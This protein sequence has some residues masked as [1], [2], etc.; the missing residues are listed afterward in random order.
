MRTWFIGSVVGGL[1]LS[2][3]PK[4]QYEDQQVQLR[5]AQAQLRQVAAEAKDC[6]MDTFLQMREQAQ[7]LDLLTAELVDRNTELA[8]EVARL[9]TF[10]TQTRSRDLD[11]DGRIQNLNQEYE[12]RLQR[13]RATYDDMVRD[14]NARIR[15]LEAENAALRRKTAETQPAR[16]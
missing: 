12:Q 4:T 2:C 9:R 3:V 8:N 11:C 10:E 5:E 13:T 1:L 16:E 14:L 15:A 6:D 7:S